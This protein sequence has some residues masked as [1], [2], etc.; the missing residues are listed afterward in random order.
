MLSE[1]RRVSRK[2][3]VVMEPNRANPLMW[4][5]SALVTEER[6]ALQFSLGFLRELLEKNRL[7]VVE[8]FSHGW[9]VPN[10][11]PA[12]FAPL[13]APGFPSALGHDEY[14]YRGKIIK[15]AVGY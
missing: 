15:S 9:M 10:K 11:T 2:Y 13:E 12:F 7:K 6:A 14:P 5:F 8:A 3:V 4:L 1:M